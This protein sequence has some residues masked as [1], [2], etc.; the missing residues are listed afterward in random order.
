M[1]DSNMDIAAIF[2]PSGSPKKLGNLNVM[3]FS[4]TEIVRT[5]WLQSPW[6]LAITLE[7]IFE[8]GSAD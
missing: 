5:L 8:T 4:Q 1:I 2:S 3:G 6:K 7:T